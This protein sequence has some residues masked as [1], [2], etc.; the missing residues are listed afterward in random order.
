MERILKFLIICTLFM[1]G[2]ALAQ[3]SDQDEARSATQSGDVLPYSQIRERVQRDHPGKVLD[4]ELDRGNYKVRVL[5]DEGSVTD[6]TVNA[7]TGEPVDVEGGGGSPR[8]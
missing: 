3:R 1:G 2:P 6:V 7:R 5:D 4:A 8:R